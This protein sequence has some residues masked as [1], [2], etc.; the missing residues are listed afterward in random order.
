MKDFVV[1]TIVFLIICSV[2]NIHAQE[3]GPNLTN[4]FKVPIKAKPF[5]LNAV[6]LNP[7]SPFYNAREKNLQYLLILEPNR[8]LHRFHKY[9]GLQPKD[10]VYSGWESEG[11]S[12][13]TLG[14]YLSAASMMYVSTNNATLKK[15]IDYVVSELAKCQQA[16]K[17]GYVG[18]YT[19]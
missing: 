18:C 14:H 1:T 11:L 2:Q 5:P 7:N 8:L 10:S 3:V 4:K 17:T 19:K 6:T 15:N 16:R 13:H 9:A 12:G